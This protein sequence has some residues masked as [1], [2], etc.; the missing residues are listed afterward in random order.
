M[1]GP[2]IDQP[3]VNSL[4]ARLP[5][6]GLPLVSVFVTEHP[7]VSQEPADSQEHT[8]QLSERG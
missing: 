8:E 3:A 1:S 6:L 2:I 4:V 5:R 7:P